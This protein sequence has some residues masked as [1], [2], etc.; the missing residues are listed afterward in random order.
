MMVAIYF[1]LTA[2]LFV[3]N[4]PPPIGFALREAVKPFQII[5]RARNAGAERSASAWRFSQFESW[6]R[7]LSG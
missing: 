5:R 1:V 2:Y 4:T 7:R 6:E 3:C